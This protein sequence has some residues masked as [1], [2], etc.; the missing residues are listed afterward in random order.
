MQYIM[1]TLDELLKASA[2]LHCH[3]C[4]RQ[5]LGVRMAMYAGKVLNI[6]LP[7]YEQ[8]FLVQEVELVTPLEKIVSRAGKRAYCQ[9]CGEEIINEREVLQDGK[10][11]CRACAGEA[12]Y[13]LKRNFQ[14]QH[15]VSVR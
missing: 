7:Q 2:A 15:F 10:V 6:D 14:F 12:Y 1:P 5:V 11:V 9:S 13:R 4:P 8:L 3:L